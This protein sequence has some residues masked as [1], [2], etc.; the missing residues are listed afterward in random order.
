V[1]T[2]A[3]I[4]LFFGSFFYLLSRHHTWMMASINLVMVAQS[5]IF[6][7]DFIIY[8]E[9]SMKLRSSGFL[10]QS[11]T[12]SLCFLNIAFTFRKCPSHICNYFSFN[13]VN[14]YVWMHHT[15]PSIGLSEPVP[16]KLKPPQNI[17]W[18][19]F[20]YLIEMSRTLNCSSFLILTNL[21]CFSWTK[22]RF[23]LKATLFSSFLQSNFYDF[24]PLLSFLLHFF[25][26]E[27]AL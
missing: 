10:D 1:L 26:L 7:R 5:N 14:A 22:N 25:E 9:V 13:Y 3:W 18:G 27:A 11:N 2:L 12:Y 19:C 20:T 17:F 24:F 4:L 8:H 21:L 23:H 15:V 16:E 6:N